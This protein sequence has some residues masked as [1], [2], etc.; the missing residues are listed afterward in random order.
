[1][2]P[3]YSQRVRRR[4]L[5]LGPDRRRPVELRQLNPGVAV[6]RPHHGDVGTNVTEPDDAVHPRPL[7][8]PLAVQLQAELGEERL[9]GL[10][11]VDNDEDVVHPLKRHP[12][13]LGSTFN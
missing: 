3:A 2:M 1:M 8:R 10:E 12:G 5:R 4:A 13:R 9:D 6:R 7:D 11:V